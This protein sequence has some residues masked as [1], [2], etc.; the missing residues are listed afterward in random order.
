MAG[1]KVDTD[2]SGR[3]LPPPDD[4]AQI[5][6]PSVW[7]MVDRVKILSDGSE[8]AQFGDGDFRYVEPHRRGERVPTEVMLREL[9]PE[10]ASI[11]GFR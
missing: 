11:Y 2:Y 1:K 3:P 10:G 4:D 5:G 6:E 9:P 8:V 7:S